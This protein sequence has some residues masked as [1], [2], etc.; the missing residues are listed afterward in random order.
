MILWTIVA[1]ALIGW[2]AAG[3]ESFGLILGGMVGAAMG[4]WLRNLF[5]AGVETAVQRH[6]ARFEQAERAKAL[7]D[8]VPT[9]PAEQ[10]PPAPPAAAAL[11]PEPARA[12]AR[13]PEPE[14]VQ[15]WPD[16]P[17][18]SP[19]KPAKPT[20]LDRENP[21]ETGL[22]KVVEWFTG[23]NT[24]VRVGLVVLFVGLVFL[25][26][27]VAN[28]GLFPIE[29]RLATVGLAG[30]ALLGVGFWKRTVR[31][32]FAL[33][34]QGAG[35]AVMYLTVYAAAKHFDVMPPTAAFGFMVVFAALGAVL[36]VMQNSRVLA[37]ASFLGGYAV[38]VLLGGEAKTPLGLFSYITIL[39]LAVMGIAWKKSWR[40]LN[41]LG[42]FAT[43]GLASLW[44]LGAYQDRH[45]LIC[46]VFLALSI[47]IYLATALLYAHNTP[48]KLGNMA[49]ST[50]LFGTALAG[51]AL[52]AGL[53]HDKPYAAAWSALAFGAVYLAV[54]WWAMQRRK[55]GMGLLFECVLAIGIGFVTMAIPL[56]LD[57]SWTGTAWAL[58][59]AGAFWVGARQARWMPRAFGLALQGLGAVLT[60]SALGFNVSAIPFANN[61]F[62]GPLL[63]AAPLIFTAWLLRREWPHSGSSWARQWIPVERQIGPLVFLAG[64]GFAVCAVFQEATRALPAVS[65]QTWPVPVFNL[66]NQMLVGMLGILG[67]MALANWFGRTREWAVATWPG[68]ASLV[69]IALSL[70]AVLLS[71]RR[72][73]DL[74]D[75][76]AWVAALGIHYRMLQLRDRA[77]LPAHSRW[78][79]GMHTGGVLLLTVMLSDALFK[80]I[81]VT[82]LWDSSWAGVV[83]LISSTAILFGLS[84]WAGRAAQGGTERHAWP[85]HPHARAYWWRAGLVLA[86]LTWIGAL[87]A[88]WAAAGDTQPLPY[89]PLLNPIDLAVGLAIAA[90]A[91]YRLVLAKADPRPRLAAW[92]AGNGGLAGLAL[93]GFTAINGVWVR[94]AHHFMGVP[95]DYTTLSSPTVLTGFSILW[96]LIAMGLM[97]LAQR[98]A[99]RLPWLAGAI[100]LG[101][102]VAKLIFVDMSQADGIARIVAFIGVGVL[103]LLIGYFV[104]LPPRKAGDS[105]AEPDAKE[106]SA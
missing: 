106:K 87:Y 19:A 11:R 28:A 2:A 45:F 25:A 94:S 89:V 4:T 64:F 71:G 31:P 34:L 51:F 53:V 76:I 62:F 3:L 73:V 15:A 17:A 26:R 93:L 95:W 42:F 81:D 92:L 24:I 1:G 47:A 101:V 100:L 96:A 41:L 32:D 58:E 9:R 21:L 91:F 35:V 83:F 6:L 57:V 68:R 20:Y 36:A 37:L 104:P 65:D 66:S 30:A 8:D 33:H 18:A 48:G 82:N 98:R 102:V 63:V 72:V 16:E 43:F 40:A 7:P 5:E 90:L 88:G 13:V 27:L 77:A 74:P 78:D 22:R 69:L 49:D 23:G 67:L 12:Q 86:A 44:G 105:G 10:A 52:Q 70:A 60:F 75:L 29:A 39:N 14:L 56:A 97:L 38:P 79:A 54:A 61:G 80:L 85:L 46:E 50:L 84:R 59:G 55:Q 103:M 99:M